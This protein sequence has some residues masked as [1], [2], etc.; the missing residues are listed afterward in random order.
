[1]PGSGVADTGGIAG[2]SSIP[3]LYVYC[4]FSTILYNI[5]QAL[6]KLIG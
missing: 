3:K 1:M 4:P 2:D 6:V 5:T